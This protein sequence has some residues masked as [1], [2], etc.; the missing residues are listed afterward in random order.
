M[1][2]FLVAIV[3]V[4]ILV[5][6]NARA[7]LDSVSLSALARKSI[8]FLSYDVTNDK[9]G[10]IESHSATGF[11]VSS[12][13]LVLTAAH[14]VREWQGQNEAEL[15]KH[16]MSGRMHSISDGKVVP[17]EP[18]GRDDQADL[19]VLKF[20]DGGDDYPT[21]S[22]CYAEDLASGTLLM[23][24]G[25]PRA[26]EFTPFPVTLANGDAPGGRWSANVNF[27]EGVSGG[28]V[29]GSDGRVVGVVKGGYADVAAV[30]YITPVIRAREM[31]RKVAVEDECLDRA[32]KSGKPARDD[33]IATLRDPSCDGNS[34]SAMF[35]VA[36]SK[37]GRRI[38]TGGRQG[39]IAIWSVP[40]GKLVQ[41]LVGDGGTVEQVSFDGSSTGERVMSVGNGRVSVWDVRSGRRIFRIG[42]AAKLYDRATWSDDDT[43]LA[44]SGMMSGFALWDGMTGAERVSPGYSAS[45]ALS[46]D[47]H[48]FAYSR[49]L[50][51]V[52]RIE[53]SSGLVRATELDDEKR[54]D[55]LK[56][57]PTSATILAAY[58]P[59][60]VALIAAQTG[61]VLA[62]IKAPGGSLKDAAFSPDGKSVALLTLNGGLGLYSKLGEHVGDLA[63]SYRKNGAPW[64][65]QAGIPWSI[66]FAEG[67]LIGAG[68]INGEV[69]VWDARSQRQTDYFEGHGP[70]QVVQVKFS[71]D[72]QYIA[73]ACFDGTVKLWKLRKGQP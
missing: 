21:T 20:R 69:V 15:G 22:L 19:A 7:E 1:R 47:G 25:F 3:C 46:P 51:V 6:T 64:A 32:A 57:D 10:E 56:V 65:G 12:H 62:Q 34:C 30:R 68:S 60:V 55:V 11:L 71:P 5:G 67:G 18:V 42:S 58:A 70:E 16:P 44:T 26:K 14:V 13:G 49:R 31:L 17:L 23:A 39:A 37:D 73:S 61:A 72:G 52:E 8:V 2:R 36:F 45:A 28:P 27:V 66:D 35:A 43:V 63:F 4:A 29:Y 40:D 9:T 59:D 54:V 50:G 53:L 38:A 41:R 24:F 48:F 33:S